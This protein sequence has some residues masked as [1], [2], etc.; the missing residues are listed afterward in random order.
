M[1]GPAVILLHG[2]SARADRWAR[3]LDGLAAAGFRVFAVDL[4]GHGHAQ[5]GA[6]FDYS[7]PGYSRWLRAFLDSLGGEPAH[8]VGTS[9]GG[10]VASAFAAD[11]PEMT[12]SL[13]CVGS[14]GL[15]PMGEAR[16]QRTIDWLPQMSREEIRRR[17]TLSV[18]DTSL[19]TDEWVEEDHRINTSPGAREAFAALA[20]Y[21]RTTIDED[22][23]VGRLA[24]MEGRFPIQ[25]LWGEKDIS[26]ATDIGVEA[27]ARLPGSRFSF[28]D[29]AAH[30]PYFERTERF[31]ALLLDVIT[32]N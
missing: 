14:I 25:L 22:A 5:K 26:V 4:P 20:D 30:L 6:G 15:L 8:I 27:H 13:T 31:N 28:I 23:T 32:S 29:G 12:R 24:A 11:H 18:V 17:L 2:L 16:R 10:L 3:N 9:F 21:Y 19:V 7:G 1:S